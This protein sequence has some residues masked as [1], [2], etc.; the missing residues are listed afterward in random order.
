MGQI[1]NMIAD[2]A[3][4][5]VRN[6]T[7]LVSAI[8]PD[9]FARLAAPAGQTV[10]SNHP[11][12]ALGHLCLYPAK[13]LAALGQD[14]SPV[15]A[16]AKF[17]ELFSKEAVCRDDADGT[18]YPPASQIIEFFSSSYAQAMAALRAASDEQ[19]AAPNPYDTPMRQ[20]CPTVGALVNFYMTG[21]VTL[22][23]GQVSAWRRM[24]GLPP[25]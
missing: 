1:G 18:L 12:F 8:A 23:L 9:R 20:L 24:E 21:H 22:H 10:V 3:S 2:T 11:A 17:E 7:R 5:G 13:V 6:A 16:P 4:V 15:Q 14:V 25:A 19:L